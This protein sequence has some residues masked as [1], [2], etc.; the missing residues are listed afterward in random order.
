LLVDQEFGVTDEVDEE[1]VPYLKPD[2]LFGFG[3]HSGSESKLREFHYL[4]HLRVS[5][6]KAEV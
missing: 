6:A 2:V 4:L 5:R 3:G 1:N